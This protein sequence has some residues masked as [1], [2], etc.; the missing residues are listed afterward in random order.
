MLVAYLADF[1]LGK[2]SPT[3]VTHGFTGDLTATVGGGTVPY[4]APEQIQGS[5]ASQKTD[6]FSLGCV[7]F[8]VCTGRRAY[9]YK[10]RSYVPGV[11]IGAKL[12]YGSRLSSLIGLCMDLH[13]PSRIGTSELVHNVHEYLVTRYPKEL[14]E[15]IWADLSDDTKQQENN[16]A[17]GDIADNLLGKGGALSWPASSWHENKHGKS[18]SVEHV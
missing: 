18:P 1:G 10:E 4:L 3:A 15:A 12:Q 7:M 16:T 8:E 13:L 11:G 9:H 14:G 2:F 5:P 6:I 17:T